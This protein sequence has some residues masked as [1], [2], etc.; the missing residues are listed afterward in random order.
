MN[1]EEAGAIV[2][3]VCQGKLAELAAQHEALKE[4]LRIVQ[5][6]VGGSSTHAVTPAS[7]HGNGAP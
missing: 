6:P 5:E 1:K 2:I 3:Q 7:P 4:A